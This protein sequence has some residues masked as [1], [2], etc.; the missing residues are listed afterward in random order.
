MSNFKLTYSV[1]P[2]SS[3][4]LDVIMC[5]LVSMFCGI[6][7][8][9]RRVSSLLWMTSQHQSRCNIGAPVMTF[10]LYLLIQAA[11][12]HPRKWHILATRHSQWMNRKNYMTCSTGKLWIDLIERM[13][14]VELIGFTERCR[15]KASGLF[16]LSTNNVLRVENM[17]PS[18]GTT[19]S[20]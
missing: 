20:M 3:M 7:A 14:V 10:A 5:A 19:L 6:V 4:V 13:L 15:R 12:Q 1:Q 18:R 16:I 11:I 9:V 8:L 17:S 2:I